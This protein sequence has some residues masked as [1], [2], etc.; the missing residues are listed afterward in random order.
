MESHVI[1]ASLV[2]FCLVSYVNCD[3][4]AH[5]Q[6]GDLIGRLVDTI[7]RLESR[8][9][10]LETSAIYGQKE[11]EE[12]RARIED[13]SEKCDTE[14]SGIAKRQGN[15]NHNAFYAYM[16]TNLQYPHPDRT[17]IFDTVRTNV[18]S[19]YSNS[20]GLFTAPHAGTFVFAWTVVVDA[21][22]F[23]FSELSVNNVAM[24]NVISDSQENNEYHTTTGMV[25]AQLSQGD[26]VKV[27]SNPKVTIHGSVLSSNTHR[28]SF[29]GFQ[30]Y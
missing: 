18:G 26:V 12:M 29:S 7:Q 30:L 13:L 3:E 22:S 14:H 25:V 27:R 16:S 1:L 19:G 20:S 10:E 9:K 2:C 23:V 6:S 4:A 21:T 17:F 11:R 5:Q 28:T 15:S 24:G 8:V